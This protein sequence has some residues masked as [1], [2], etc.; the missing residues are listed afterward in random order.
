[1]A[2]QLALEQALGQAGAVDHHQRP[3]GARAGLVH[4]RATSSLPVPD[5]PSSSTLAVDGAHA[6]HQ[7]QHG[8]R[9]ALR[10]IRPCAAGSLGARRSGSIFSM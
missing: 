8:G 2:E 7:R 3:R 1:V 10:P 9:P 6:R 5:S 4:G